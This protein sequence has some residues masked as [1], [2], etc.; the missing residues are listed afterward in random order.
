M[1]INGSNIYSP[2]GK[3]AEPA[4]KATTNFPYVFY[5]YSY[6]SIYFIAVG[7]EKTLRCCVRYYRS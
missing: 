6:Y 1:R 5:I 7:P 3:F 2:V 4:K